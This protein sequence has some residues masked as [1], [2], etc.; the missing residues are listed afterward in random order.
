MYAISILNP[1]KTLN[2]TQCEA[3]ANDKAEA[4]KSLVIIKNKM[5][6]II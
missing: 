1:D 6:P 2:T 5:F 4:V 3:V